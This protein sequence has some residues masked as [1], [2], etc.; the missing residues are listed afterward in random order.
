MATPTATGNNAAATTTS[1]SSSSSSSS[2]GIGAGAAAGIGVGVGAGVFIIAAAVAF[3]FFRNRK[4]SHAKLQDSSGTDDPQPGWYLGQQ[5]ALAAP[6]QPIVYELD[7]ADAQ[8]KELDSR[9]HTR[10]A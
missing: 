7:Q 10:P 8:P 3:L 1:S 2:P 4:L 9:Q 6:Q 5:Q